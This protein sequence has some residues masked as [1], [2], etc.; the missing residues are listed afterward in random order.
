MAQYKDVTY[1]KPHPKKTRQGNSSNTKRGL[2]G[3]KK[4]VKP[5]RGQGKR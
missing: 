3:S 2:K 1:R 4:Y 5:Y